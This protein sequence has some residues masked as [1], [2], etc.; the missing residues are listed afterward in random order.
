LYLISKHFLTFIKM[1]LILKF[2]SSQTTQ[3]FYK[4][5]LTPDLYIYMDNA[6]SNYF[7][8]SLPLKYKSQLYAN[9]F[10]IGLKDWNV[11]NKKKRLIDMH[12][13]SQDPIMKQSYNT[14]NKCWLYDGKHLDV[15][16]MYK[17]IC[18]IPRNKQI[19]DFF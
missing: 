9:H 4:H 5:K 16:D 15:H 11:K 14:D 7:Y 1:N 6:D 2:W 10:T 17:I 12:Y 3:C 18:E 13:T 19:L 8:F